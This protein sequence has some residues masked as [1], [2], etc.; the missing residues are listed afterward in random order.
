MKGLPGWRPYIKLGAIR[1]LLTVNLLSPSLCTCC[2]VILNLSEYT[3]H[4]DFDWSFPPDFITGP[5]RCM[6]VILQFSRFNSSILIQY[7]LYN[8]C[9]FDQIT[10]MIIIAYII[11]K[12]K[13][14]NSSLWKIAIYLNVYLLTVSI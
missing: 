5:N 9:Y 1:L 10:T 4:H 11:E 2:I 8:I 7:Y 3:H 13:H 6:F 14:Y 12:S